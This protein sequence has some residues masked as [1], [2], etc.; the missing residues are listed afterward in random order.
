MA[1]EIKY[2]IC[3][4]GSRG[5][6]KRGSLKEL[7]QDIPYALGPDDSVLPTRDE[8]NRVLAEGSRDAGMSGCCDW[9]PFQVSEEEYDELT[10]ELLTEPGTR[11][12]YCG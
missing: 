12:G 4:I 6:W 11:F 3:P 5:V 9:A 7:L 8:L 1:H 2:K 10:L